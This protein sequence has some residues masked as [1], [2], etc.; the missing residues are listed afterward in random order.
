MEIKLTLELNASTIWTLRQVMRTLKDEL[1]T[2]VDYTKS[3]YLDAYRQGEEEK[4]LKGRFSTY[5]NKLNELCEA[6]ALYTR[7]NELDALIMSMTQI[8]LKRQHEKED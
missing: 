7:L 5:L 1:A 6:E 2:D 8:D 3:D 4:I